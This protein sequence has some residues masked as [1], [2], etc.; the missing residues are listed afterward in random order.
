[1]RGIER[2]L[3]LGF[4]RFDGFGHDDP[5]LCRAAVDDAHRIRRHAAL[6]NKRERRRRRCVDA[7]DGG[8]LGMRRPTTPVLR[9][10]LRGLVPRLELPRKSSEIKTHLS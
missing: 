5:V 2:R 8:P 6:R 7:D 1:L 9:R 10:E 4:A 3:D